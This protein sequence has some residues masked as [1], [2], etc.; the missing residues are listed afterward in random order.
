MSHSDAQERLIGALL[1]IPYQATIDHV[2]RHLADAGYTDLS[3][4]HFSVFQHLPPGGAR[5][6][7]LASSAQMTKQSMSALVEHLLERG[8]LERRPDPTDGRASLVTLTERGAALVL[9]ARKAI[10]ELEQE[11]NEYLGSERMEQLRTT[12]RDLANLIE[13]QQGRTS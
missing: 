5:V 7:M 9:V 8:Y 10:Q 6:T 11:W 2:R 1:R 4:A 12:L 3:I 13:R